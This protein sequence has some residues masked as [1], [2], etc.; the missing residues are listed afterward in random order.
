ML[1]GLREA[2]GALKRA[3]HSGCDLDITELANGVDNKTVLRVSDLRG[4]YPHLADP[5]PSMAALEEQLAANGTGADASPGTGTGVVLAPGYEHEYVVKSLK[6]ERVLALRTSLLKLYAEGSAELRARRMRSLMAP[7][8]LM[9]TLR[10][11]SG[12][13]GWFGKDTAGAPQTWIVMRRVRLTDSDAAEVG[14]TAKAY[15]V[16]GLKGQMA[17]GAK[18]G[19]ALMKHMGAAREQTSDLGFLDTFPLGLEVMRAANQGCKSCADLFGMLRA[20]S[21]IL[22]SMQMT[23]YSMLVEMYEA[24]GEVDLGEKCTKARFPSLFH[25]RDPYSKKYF[26][27]AIGITNFGTKDVANP[28][29]VFSTRTQ[30]STYRKNFEA[31]FSKV[32][33]QYFSCHDSFDEY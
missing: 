10:P 13:S 23:D 1:A 31:I 20:D 9:A 15:K 26:V 3:S 33:H 11:R 12:G 21:A 18:Q 32:G 17:M 27:V 19:N 29:L 4:C 8:C 14:V 6:S 30:P 7:V 22:E 5:C 25:A 2:I 24:D 28:M 16:F